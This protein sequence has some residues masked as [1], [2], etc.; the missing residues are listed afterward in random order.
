[1]TSKHSTVSIKQRRQMMH[2]FT[3][4]LFLCALAIALMPLGNSMKDKTMLIM[5][6]SGA[7]FWVGLLGTIYMV[8]KINRVRKGNHR[9]NEFFGNRK[10]LGL[11][12]FFQNT[13]AMIADMAMIVSI[14]ALVI[15]VLCRANLQVIY[16][17]ISMFVFTFGMHCMLNGMNYKYINYSKHIKE[18]KKD[19]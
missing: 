19:E 10:Q 2:L 14:I 3:G 6:C 18:Q 17:I 9:F 15:A 7:A 1:M 5:Y 11:I 8:L 4:F 12:H 13:K 16:F